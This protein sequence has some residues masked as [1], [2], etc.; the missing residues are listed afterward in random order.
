[1]TQLD[2]EQINDA[3]LRYLEITDRIEQLQAQQSAIKAQFRELEPGKHQTVGGVVLTVTAPPRTFNAN[4]AWSM[5]SED[6]KDVCTS[7][8]PKKIK[9]QLPPALTEACMDPGAGEP[10]VSIK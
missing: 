4:R 9:A 6:Q 7:P 8:D 1:M 5:L 2:T 10:R 3:V